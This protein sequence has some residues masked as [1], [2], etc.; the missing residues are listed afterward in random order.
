[1]VE[2]RDPFALNLP[3]LGAEHHSCQMSVMIVTKNNAG[4]IIRVKQLV[5]R[6]TPREMELCQQFGTDIDPRESLNQATRLVD[7]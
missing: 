5:L 3:E 2:P 1:M 7:Q 4:Q 6:P